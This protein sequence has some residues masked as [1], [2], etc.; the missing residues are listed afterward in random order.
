MIKGLVSV[1]MSAYNSEKTIE[2]SIMSILNQTYEDWELILVNDF[3]SDTTLVILEGFTRKESR[4]KIINNNK[5]IGLTA[6]LN[7]A[8]NISN[9]EFIARLDSDDVAEPERL[10]KQVS[11]LVSNPDIGMVGTGANLIDK[12]G[13]KIGSMS[14]ISN[15]YLVS[16]FIKYLNPFIHSS[17][18]IRKRVLDDVGIYR[19]KFRYSQDYDLVLR[20]YDRYK[21]VNMPEHLISWRV[22]E[23]SITMQKNILQRVFA[24]IAKKLAHER[25]INGRDSYD[26]IDFDAMINETESN[27]KGR[28]LCDNGVYNILFKRKY[29]D[30]LLD[31]LKGFSKGGFPY[32]SFYRFLILTLSKIA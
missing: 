23:G 22:S 2:D 10:K 31:L 8:I 6:S 26:I 21:A 30:G 1:V 25:R 14:V 3:S 9:G 13:R 15:E 20:V 11:F 24:D 27:N 19:E 28:Y 12:D 5:N 4:I 16:R 29:K 17:L 18:M 7:K 32:N